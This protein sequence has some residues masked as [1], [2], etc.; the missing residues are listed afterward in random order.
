MDDVA[1]VDQ[2]LSTL[3]STSFV[4]CL[5][6]SCEQGRSSRAVTIHSIT[7]MLASSNA[8]QSL[9]AQCRSHTGY[10]PLENQ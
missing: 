6:G 10:P 8:C 1:L 9:S 7:L 4:R 5:D 3:F 2:L